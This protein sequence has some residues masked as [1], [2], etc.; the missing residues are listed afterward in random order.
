MK[1]IASTIKRQQQPTDDGTRNQCTKTWSGVIWKR[2]KTENHTQLHFKISL[3]YYLLF[4]FSSHP[5]G[6]KETFVNLYT[7][8]HTSIKFNTKCK[9]YTHST[10]NNWPFEWRTT[11][12]LVCPMSFKWLTLIYIQKVLRWVTSIGITQRNS[13]IY[14]HREKYSLFSR[15]FFVSLSLKWFYIYFR[16]QQS[17]PFF[18]HRVVVVR[19]I[20]FLFSLWLLHPHNIFKTRTMRTAKQRCQVTQHNFRVY[21]ARSDKRFNVLRFYF[22]LSFFPFFFFRMYRKNGTSQY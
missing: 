9:R 13:R 21:L 16:I 10:A 19:T 7:A 11:S 18:C 17:M 22:A 12:S 14:T 15:C 5:A 1:T 6:T 4:S 3:F 20:W 2:P 8:C